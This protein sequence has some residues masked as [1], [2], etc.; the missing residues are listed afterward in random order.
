MRVAGIALDATNIGRKGRVA[1]MLNSPDVVAMTCPPRKPFF[2][3]RLAA[4]VKL[5]E[6]NGGGHFGQGVGLR[7]ALN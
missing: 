4:H 1:F 3:K 5:T 2:P 7:T 6:A